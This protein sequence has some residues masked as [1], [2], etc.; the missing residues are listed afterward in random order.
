MVY[1]RH[2]FAHALERETVAWS[3]EVIMALIPDRNGHAVASVR[4]VSLSQVLVTMLGAGM[5]TLVIVAAMLMF[6]SC[7]GRRSPGAPYYCS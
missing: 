1:L 3:D 2:A 7:G 5:V 6:L 4:H